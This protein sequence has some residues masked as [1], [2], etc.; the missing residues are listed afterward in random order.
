MDSRER[1]KRRIFAQNFLVDAVVAKRI[2]DAAELSSN[3]SVLEIGPG[4]GALTGIIAANAKQVIAIEKDAIQAEKMIQKFVNSNVNVIQ[5]D[6][7]TYAYEQHFPEPV[8]GIGNYVVISNLPYNAASHIL[9]LLLSSYNRPK[10]IIAMVQKEVAHRIAAKVGDLSILGITMQWHADIKVLFDVDPMAFRP[11]PNVY[12]TVI[13][14][15]PKPDTELLI[16]RDKEKGIFRLVRIGFSS[17]RKKLSNNVSSGL[18]V[19]R[20][21]VEN[22]LLE[23]GLPVAVRAQDLSCENWLQLAKK[24]RLVDVGR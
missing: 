13:S 21:T 5:A 2:V 9:Q 16:S 1:N 3:D 8:D 20:E 6:A 23:M 14:I 17:K 10:K 4:D 15:I 19:P 24:L 11:K 7:T 22:F 12:S 18:Q